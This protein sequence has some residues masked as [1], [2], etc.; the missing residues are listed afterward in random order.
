[1]KLVCDCGNEQE[2]ITLC[3]TDWA[4]Y[5]RSKIEFDND[6]KRIYFICKECKKRIH[7]LVY[8]CHG[9]NEFDK[10]FVELEVKTKQVVC[11]RHNN[12]SY[13]FEVTVSGLHPLEKKDMLPCNSYTV[14][15]YEKQLR[16]ERKRRKY[17]AD[18]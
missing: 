8:D 11:L 6:H 9:T 13:Y 12:H 7:V 16:E 2:I 4:D 10:K 5:D 3:D 17:E 15:D 14:W 1:M 18:L